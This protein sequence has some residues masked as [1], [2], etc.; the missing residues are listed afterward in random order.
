[1]KIIKDTGDKLKDK[2]G[3]VIGA[4]GIKS[5]WDFIGSMVKGLVE[6]AKRNPKEGVSIEE[7]FESA[8]IRRGLDEEQ[9]T[10]NYQNLVMQ[11]YL[12]GIIALGGLVMFIS[13]LMSGIYWVIA[14]FLGFFIMCGG[15]MFKSSYRAYQIR[16]REFVPSKQWFEDKKAWVPSFTLPKPVKKVQKSVTKRKDPLK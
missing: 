16:L 6:V 10:L 9:L 8:C 15:M 5:G 3:Q 13:N 1:M 11:F 2:A 4:D 14:P 12:I 7:S